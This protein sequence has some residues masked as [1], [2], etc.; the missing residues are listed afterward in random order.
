MNSSAVLKF[1]HPPRAVGVSCDDEMLQVQLSDG[2]EIRVP[3]AYFPRLRD[4]TP[5]ARAKCRIIGNGVG[6]HWEALDEDL[7]VAGLLAA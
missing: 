2:R 5:E 1:R 7:S 3:L 6:I 4:A